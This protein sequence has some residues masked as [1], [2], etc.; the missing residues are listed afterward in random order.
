M[1]KRLLRWIKTHP[2]RSF[3]LILFFPVYGFIFFLSIA[4]PIGLARDWYYEKFPFSYLAVRLF[5]EPGEDTLMF[6][7]RLGDR[8]LY[9]RSDIA[10]PA[11]YSGRE[12]AICNP[13]WGECRVF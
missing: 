6:R 7:Y 9:V 4:I 13:L 11:R 12:E 8:L 10:R 1:L 2:I 5:A 3:F